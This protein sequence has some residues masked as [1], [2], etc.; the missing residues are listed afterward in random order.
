MDSSHE[1]DDDWGEFKST[2][3]GEASPSAEVSEIDVGAVE[4]SV[5][6]GVEAFEASKL[7]AEA[8]VVERSADGQAGTTRSISPA[9]LDNRM[10]GASVLEARKESGERH[11]KMLGRPPD[12]TSPTRPTLARIGCGTTAAEPESGDVERGGKFSVRFPEQESLQQQITTP[13]LVGV[14]CLQADG[15]DGNHDGQELVAAVFLEVTETG[16]NKSRNTRKNCMNFGYPHLQN[17]I[18]PER[19]RWN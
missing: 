13:V 9:G 11:G 14:E 7:I 4:S 8:V 15:V 5:P 1:E 18:R 12:N 17:S 19:T 3:N 2:L 6:S 10:A 16:K